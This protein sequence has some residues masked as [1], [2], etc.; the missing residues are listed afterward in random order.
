MGAD[1]RIGGFRRFIAGVTAV[2]LMLTPISAEGSAVF[3]SDLGISASAEDIVPLDGSENGIEDNIG[4]TDDGDANENASLQADLG[5]SVVGEGVEGSFGEA[6]F[7]PDMSSLPD[8]DELFGEFIDLT[9]Y[10]SHGVSVFSDGSENGL[11]DEGEREVYG[12]LKAELIK[13]AGGELADTQVT[14]ASDKWTYTEESFRSVI[15][16]LI[17]DIPCELYWLDK[18]A[19][20]GISYASNEFTFKFAA[21]EG[22]KGASQY[23]VDTE[24]T[25]A[26]SKAAANALSIVEKYA[27]R[28]D[29]AKLNGYRSEV[30]GL[31]EGDAVSGGYGDSWQLIYA[32][33]GDTS[34]DIACEGYSKAFQYLCDMTDFD[35]TSIKS[36]VVTGDMDGEAHVWNIVSIDGVSYFAD[37]MNCDEGRIG[38][39]DPMFLKGA[40]D[41]TGDGFTAKANGEAVSY[42]YDEAA[43]SAFPASF[44]TVSTEDYALADSN[45][46]TVK[47]STTSDKIMFEVNGSSV[48]GNSVTVSESD[49]VS[50]IIRNRDYVNH[51]VTINGE[52]VDLVDHKID[53]ACTDVIHSICSFKANAYGKS[54]LIVELKE[55]IWDSDRLSG[56]T[57]LIIDERLSFYEG[58]Y[59][60]CRDWPL[61]SGD[62]VHG[63]NYIWTSIKI[64]DYIGYRFDINGEDPEDYESG[65]VGLFRLKYKE[66]NVTL[67][68]QVQS[69]GETKVELQEK[70]WSNDQLS[71]FVRLEIGENINV[72]RYVLESEFY[73]E[74]GGTVDKSYLLRTGDYYQK[75]W[76]QG[77][78]ILSYSQIFI[79]IPEEQINE[80]KKVA[81]NG[82]VVEGNQIYYTIGEEDTLKIELVSAVMLTDNNGF[83]KEFKS[84][85]EACSYIN[86]NG[87]TDTDYTVD[88]RGDIS[89]DK[90]V[91]PTKAKS[92]TFTG[93]GRFDLDMTSL[94]IP[95]NTKFEVPV[96][97]AGTKPLT[98]KVAAGKTLTFSKSI[99]N[100]GVISGTKTS[101]LCIDGNTEAASI[102][103]FGEV[104]VL[105][106][107]VLSVTGNITAVTHFS[108]TLALPNAKSAAALGTVGN[109]ELKLTDTDGANANATVT[110]VDSGCTLLISV[111]DTNDKLIPLESGR[112]VL[113][114]GSTVDFTNNITVANTSTT[115]QKLTAYLYG[116]TIKAEYSEAV[117]LSTEDESIP[118]IYP[119]LEMAFKE[120][121]DPEAT[122]T[123]DLNENFTLSKLTIPSK[124]HRIII[125]GTGTLELDM[126]S[127][128]IPVNMDFNTAVSGVN[129]KPLDIKLVAG[130]TLRIN[131]DVK[132]IGT[133]TGTKTSKLRINKYTV[134]SG[135][136]T[137]G[138]VTAGEGLL[139]T[140]NIS[141]LTN[142]TGSLELPNA[143]SSAN[144]TNIKGVTIIDRTVV[145]GS[146]AKLTVSHIDEGYTLSIMF[147]SNNSLIPI[148][149]GR[150][151][152]TAGSA[153]DLGGSISISNNSTSGKELTAYR[154]GKD[155]KAEYG[156][157]VELKIGSDD[158]SNYPNLD[159]AL[160]QITDPTKNYTI[161]LNEDVYADKLVFPTKAKS[162]TIV[163]TGN[164]YLNMAS[165]NI[166]VDM[167]IGVDLNGTNAKPLAVK[168]A[169]GK[170]LGIVSGS[171]NIGVI[172]GTKTSEFY[173]DN[174]NI[175]AAGISTF[176]KVGVSSGKIIVT[177][178]VAG[179]TTLEGTLALPN[180]RSTAAITNIE[181]GALKLTDTNG[182]AA[183]VTVSN[184][185]KKLTIS[186]VDA[187]GN[188]I[189]IESGRTVL[190]AGST[191]DFTDKVA[192]ENSSK[193]GLKLSAYL[194][195]K[196]VKA[197][198]GGAV[199]LSVDGEENL[200]SYP[201]LDVAFKKI[202]DQSKS[203]TITLNEKV[204]ADK[205][206]I[207]TKAQSITFNGNG[208]L[209]L[210]M[211]SLNIP[212]N[213]VFEVPVNGTNAKPLAVK[214][215]AGKKL[216]FSKE[217]SNIGAISGTKTSELHIDS[218]DIEVIGISTFNKVQ[219]NDVKITVTG[220]V[221]GVTTLE[222]TLAL[223]NV[224]STAAI[225]NIGASGAAVIMADINEKNAKVTVTNVDAEGKLTLK[226]VDAN[227]GLTYLKNSREI[228]M[229]GSNIDFTNR[230]AIENRSITGSYFRAYC[231]GKTIKAESAVA[232]R[233]NEDY[234][235]N[236]DLALKQ[237]TDASTDYRIKLYEEV[238][239]NKL[240]FPAKANSITIDAVGIDQVSMKSVGLKLDM[241]MLNIPVNMEFK[242]PV[243]GTN[244]KPL[245][246]KV[247]A[248]KALTFTNYSPENIGTISGTKTSKLCLNVDTEVMGI[249]TFEKV[250]A[251]ECKLTVTG[252][253]TG[254]NELNGMLALTNA[255]SAANITSIG[256]ADIML[257][258]TDGANAKVTVSNVNEKLTISIVDADGNLIPLENG[259]TIL[260]AGSTADFKG[261]VFIANKSA[262]GK[263]LTAY[264]YGKT[265]KAEYSESAVLS[266][267]NGEIGKYPNLALA[268]TAASEAKDYTITLNGDV[269]E[270]S[271]VLP[272]KASS[273]TIKSDETHTLDIG[274]TAAVSAKIPLT[275]EN[276]NIRGAKSCTVTA[277][278]DLKFSGVKSD[279]ISAIKDNAQSTLTILN[280]DISYTTKTGT[281]SP[282][283]TGFGTVEIDGA[284][285]VGATF[286]VKTL[287]L[288]TNAVFTVPT[289]KSSV[290]TAALSG[291]DGAKM[292]LSTGFTPIRITGTTEDAVTGKITITSDERF[293]KS[294]CIF[295]TKTLGTA[296][297]D[298]SN[299]IPEG[300]GADDYTLAVLGGKAYLKKSS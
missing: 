238:Y 131:A 186:I 6:Q 195:G 60:G 13:I 82:I 244:A 176:N 87:N 124:A 126:T 210:N 111:I 243:D 261:K 117:K 81:A 233:V 197:E 18:T 201:N 283:I 206:V 168:V 160:K 107:K 35:N 254:V 248:G 114:A 80:G 153:A 63:Q 205:L 298:V 48:E 40:Y 93:T 222:G 142:F 269:C 4:D 203:Y 15:N 58:N 227:G 231:Y 30:C 74:W 28:D 125:G 191:A 296:E 156:G 130:K 189:P 289:G 120:I 279:C 46:S 10:G 32:F 175:E 135:I 202:T 245:A 134:L 287:K 110:N 178:N 129:A 146:A 292:H 223:P 173:V 66:D 158:S 200:K 68:F 102:A 64:K 299:I 161:T 164:L 16:A 98:I 258:D 242:V 51:K 69:G 267:E 9:F 225:T 33:D 260:T 121:T 128:N 198:Y 300:A 11:A 55:D 229:A 38:S 42:A 53:L 132:N 104:N 49:T 123:I 177:G 14:V 50:V 247:A 276:I 182:A 31:A 265:I 216:A 34:T 67:A 218:A 294:V 167:Y 91:I 272:T 90:L 92:I 154:Y 194:Y 133:I 204:T 221:A 112:A 137:L 264:R 3:G 213:T 230:I 237:I 295:V 138:F 280:S 255:R 151:I 150:T 140:G 59:T 181:T 246:I 71:K 226:F 54:D 232:V 20:V 259:R 119:N 89:A 85:D 211:T 127:L 44:L 257:T 145:N 83:E 190:T 163:G 29:L 169:A 277:S 184:V 263:E 2:L 293:D 193:S 172:S 266:D 106:D 149:S 76:T 214:V 274:N 212:V 108:G 17:A 57:K 99:S 36:A 47:I 25:G 179:V 170:I 240:V 148:E 143:D 253:V 252:N 270:T 207:P 188:L 56:Y 70:E 174:T 224:K 196:T 228:L 22:Y 8:D 97:G 273:L 162:I 61:K 147:S 73:P 256:T 278:A 113:T 239:T 94:N 79:E 136:S 281:A 297:F 271:L 262:S 208:S 241:T 7:V 249:S 39:G 286:T 118:K 159:A 157:A 1:R 288:G 101:E 209:E 183:K 41:P 268:L 12:L 100:I 152:L 282:N 86:K 109:A 45:T 37:I 171:K 155:I 116:K 199:T 285:T 75:S 19:G 23:T 96:N 95:V 215:S 27:D 220:N 43:K 284:F 144:I 52:T 187:E 21:A 141:A 115:D 217:P 251:D 234:Y 166:P 122:Y 192:I 78:Q 236:I 105:T 165:L 139:V 180:A 275:L 24:K 5:G 185:T 84:L 250:Q 62:Y 235:S 77:G 26:A 103:T 290:S 72:Y 291:E 65:A 88:L 219:V